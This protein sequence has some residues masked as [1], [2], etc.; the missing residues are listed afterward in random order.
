MTLAFLP[1]LGL[2]SKK[3]DIS[4]AFL[5]GETLVRSVYVKP[6]P[7]AGVDNSECWL[8]LKVIYG[9]TDASRMWYDRVDEVLVQDNCKRSSVDPAL[10]LKYSNNCDLVGIILC[11]VDDFLYSGTDDEIA[12]IESFTKKNFEVRKIEENMFMFSRFEIEIIDMNNNG[13]PSVNQE[14]SLI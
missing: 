9:L 11:H 4:T 12:L 14:R 3:M 1:T 8:L 7:E 5:Q 10:Y 2:R 13:V 6:P